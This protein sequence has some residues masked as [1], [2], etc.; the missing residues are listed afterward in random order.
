DAVAQATMLLV[1]ALARRWPKAQASL[2]RAI[3][4]VPTGVEL[5]GRTLLVVGLGRTGGRVAELGR[6]FG[7][8]VESVRSAEGRMGLLAALPRADFVTIHVPLTRET[9]AL[10]DDEAFA[11]MRPGAFLIN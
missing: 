2:A 5:A 9:R 1:L 11:A 7:M 8:N 6:A 10:F 4:G 3:I